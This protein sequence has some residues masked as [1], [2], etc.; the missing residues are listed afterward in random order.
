MAI[1]GGQNVEGAPDVVVEVV[2]DATAYGDLVMKEC[3]Y[4][5]A[6]V[7][8]YWIADPGERAVD[9]LRLHGRSYELHRRFHA[10]DTLESP[11]LE[12]LSVDLASVF[13]WKQAEGRSRV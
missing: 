4:A 7:K 1:I 2:S 11:L 3:L 13:A 9:V 10:Q 12:G 5:Q 6:G 8:E